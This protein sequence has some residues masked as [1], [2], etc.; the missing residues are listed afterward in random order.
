MSL[1]SKV[2]DT[3]LPHP[4]DSATTTRTKTTLSNG[5]G[6][7]ISRSQHGDRQLL[8]HETISQFDSSKA[9]EE[10]EMARPPYLHVR[11]IRLLYVIGDVLLTLTL[12][13]LRRCSLVV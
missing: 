13:P 3:V 10:E 2:I 5:E 7:G 1:I 11:G 9:M 4:I 6:D 8:P 12:P